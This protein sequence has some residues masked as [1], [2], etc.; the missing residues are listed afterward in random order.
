M[1]TLAEAMVKASGKRAKGNRKS[2]DGVLDA[3]LQLSKKV[4]SAHAV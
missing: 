3:N 2:G 1:L 4:V